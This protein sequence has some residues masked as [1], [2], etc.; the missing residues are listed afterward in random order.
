M[1]LP[2]MPETSDDW[3]SFEK[4]RRRQ[5]RLGLEMTPLERL[6]WLDEKVAE[7]RALQGLVQRSRSTEPPP[8]DD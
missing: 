6:H 1:K 8:E 2:P 4:T 5:I 7:M 3:G